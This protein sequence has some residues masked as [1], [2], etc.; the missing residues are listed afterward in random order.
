ML[1][2]AGLLEGFGRQ[3]ITSDILRYAVAIA[4]GLFWCAYFYVLQ[5]HGNGPE[6]GRR[7]R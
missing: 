4:T 2:A 7:R 3:L 6:T 1:F 5:V